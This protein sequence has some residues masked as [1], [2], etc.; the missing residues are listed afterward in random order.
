[1]ESDLQQEGLQTLR[2]EACHYV[3]LIDAYRMNAITKRK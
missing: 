2:F 3:G 1:M